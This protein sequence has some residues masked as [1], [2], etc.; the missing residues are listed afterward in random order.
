[1]G[2]QIF[3]GS[4]IVIGITS[5]AFRNMKN[6]YYIQRLM[7]QTKVPVLIQSGAK[8]LSINVLMG[9]LLCVNNIISAMRV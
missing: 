9:R 6:F 3:S 7:L 5:H 4:C 1:M 2:I 8:L